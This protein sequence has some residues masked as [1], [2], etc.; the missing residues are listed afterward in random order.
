MR[1][2]RVI[3]VVTAMVAVSFLISSQ[4]LAQGT[5]NAPAKSLKSLVPESDPNAY[6]ETKQYQSATPEEKAKADAWEKYMR[7]LKSRAKAGTLTE[8]EKKE[9]GLSNVSTNR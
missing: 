4:A 2:G 1:K 7:D 8:K 3:V 9:L 5:T 6:K